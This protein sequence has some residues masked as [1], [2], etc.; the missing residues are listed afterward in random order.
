[1]GGLCRTQTERSLRQSNVFARQSG[2][3]R[4]VMKTN[5]ERISLP[6]YDRNPTN[7]QIVVDAMPSFSVAVPFVENVF[8]GRHFIFLFFSRFRLSVFNII[9]NQIFLPRV[10]IVVE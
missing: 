3:L 4:T 8:T 1:M 7:L 9:L 5:K 6:R 2:P 10:R